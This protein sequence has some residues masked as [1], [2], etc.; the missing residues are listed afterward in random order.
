MNNK[1]KIWLIVAT[2]FVVVGCITFVSVMNALNWDFSKLSTVKYETNNHV[3]NSDF[4]NI[5]IDTNTAE[6]KLVPS[7][8]SVCKVVCYEEDKVQHSVVV[9]ENTLKIEVNDSRKWYNYIGI[10]FSSPKITVYLPEEKYG[11][12]D[13]SSHTGCV[14]ISKEYTFDS[15]DIS[16]DTGDI[17]SYASALYSVKLAASTGKISI[18]RIT[19]DSLDVLTSTGSV[20]IS[21]VTCNNDIKINVST[22]KITLSDTNC[23]SF[24]SNASTGDTS[25]C[26]V[27][28]QSFDI[29]TSTGNVNFEGCDAQEI[30]VSTD[31]GDISGTLLSE[32]IFVTDTDT[33][34]ISV[35]KSTSGGLCEL[36]TDTGDIDIDVID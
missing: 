19:A 22:G 12:L 35:P 16:T 3:I 28:A 23:L 14:E 7:E 21:N 8:D 1:S 33:G 5:S 34:E 29:E 13:I 9:S 26:N 20:N 10:N 17:N 24:V 11:K 32:K 25:L 31:T 30:S 15:I 36:T 2:V 6:I 27:H 18:D 4:N